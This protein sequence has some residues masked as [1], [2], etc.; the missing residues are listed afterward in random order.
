MV[1]CNLAKVDVASSSLV[2]RSPSRRGLPL[3]TERSCAT[4]G[5]SGAKKCQILGT[6]LAPK[7]GCVEPLLPWIATASKKVPQTESRGCNIPR[8]VTPHELE[9]M[10]DESSLRQIFPVSKRTLYRWIGRG[11]PSRLI[12]GRRLFR[13]SA[14]DRWLRQFDQGHWGEGG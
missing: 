2:T 4:K 1:E 13:P 9:P 3:I 7:R 8:M 12:S 11:C 10:V 6:K 5:S 14:V